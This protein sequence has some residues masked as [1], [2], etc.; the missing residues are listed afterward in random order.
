MLLGC[1]TPDD[2]IPFLKAIDSDCEAKIQIV[3]CIETS[4]IPVIAHNAMDWVKCISEY[5]GYISHVCLGEVFEMVHEYKY[6]KSLVTKAIDSIQGSI[7]KSKVS[8]SLSVNLFGEPYT[9]DL[10]PSECMFNDDC[11]DVLKDIFDGLSKNSSPLFIKISPYFAISNNHGDIPN[12]LLDPTADTYM[13][14]RT[15]RYNYVFDAMVC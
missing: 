7:K 3:L 9:A 2:A 11:K 10:P 13:T 1:K 6:D 4:Q 14:D 5:E 15:F 12:Y 8:T